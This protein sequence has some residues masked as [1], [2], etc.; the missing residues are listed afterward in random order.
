MQR[1]SQVLLLRLSHNVNMDILIMLHQ[2]TGLIQACQQGQYTPCFTFQSNGRS[3]SE[4]QRFNVYLKSRGLELSQ[5]HFLSVEPCLADSP[6]LGQM[7]SPEPFVLSSIFHSLPGLG[8]QSGYLLI[9]PIYD[10]A[11]CVWAMFTPPLRLMIA[12][13]CFVICLCI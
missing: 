4:L 2:L 6:H 5:S 9:T 12:A 11:R 8:I 1:G 7:P 10:E 13:Q 3:W